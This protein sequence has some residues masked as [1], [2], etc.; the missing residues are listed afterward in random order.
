MS[1]A[2]KINCFARFFAK[3]KK[4]NL[5]LEN[6]FSEVASLRSAY[7]DM[8]V[9]P[10]ENCTMI[11]VNYADLCLID[12]HVTSLL[13]CA[14]LELRELKTRSTVLG[15]YTTCYLLRSDLEA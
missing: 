10:C 11:M 9:K 5:V 4:F 6:A 8:S 3:N 2:T 15:A 1:F 14:S 13:D 7:D 12:S